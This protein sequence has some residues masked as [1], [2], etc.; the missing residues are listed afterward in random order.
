MYFNPGVTG[1]E[2]HLYPSVA[3][4]SAVG[5]HDMTVLGMLPR[6]TPGTPPASGARPP[7]PLQ[8]PDKQG[9]KDSED[10]TLEYPQACLAIYG[11]WT[12]QLHI[13]ELQ[14]A[15]ASQAN[16]KPQGTKL[17]ELLQVGDNIKRN[18]LSDAEKEVAELN[19]RNVFARGAIKMWRAV[20]GA[21]QSHVLGGSASGKTTST[22]QAS[23][24]SNRRNAVAGDAAAGGAAAG[25]GGGN[26]GNGGNQ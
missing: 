11:K 17:E 4:R 20:A 16:M 1:Y 15:G 3:R 2:L 6:R 24:S 21:A 13:V 14:P 18:S 22:G 19:R 7:G 25:A 26:G 5:A 8:F 9:G 10:I 12:S 23:K